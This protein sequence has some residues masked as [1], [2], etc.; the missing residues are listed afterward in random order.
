MYRDS[1]QLVFPCH[2]SISNVYEPADIEAAKNISH[3]Y[4]PELE[5]E[6][7]ALVIGSCPRSWRGG[8]GAATS[9]LTFGSDIR[10]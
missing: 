5:K 7:L 1:S 4:W 6:M 8:G 2:L 9:G 3:L 10:P